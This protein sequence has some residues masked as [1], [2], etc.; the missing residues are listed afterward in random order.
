VILSDFLAEVNLFDEN[1]WQ[2]GC[3]VIPERLESG[4]Q[5]RNDGKQVFLLPLYNTK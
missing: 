5:I 1:H 2:I 4:E 3:E